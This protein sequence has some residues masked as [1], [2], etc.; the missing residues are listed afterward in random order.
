MPKKYA[1]EAGRT[2]VELELQQMAVFVFGPPFVTLNNF[3]HHAGKLAVP[4]R[5]ERNAQKQMHR[6]VIQSAYQPPGCHCC[7]H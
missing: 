6:H 3:G 4:R 7:R 2:H 1:E 5:N